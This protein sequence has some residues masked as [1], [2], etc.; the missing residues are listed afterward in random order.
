M[1]D[2]ELLMHLMK[3]PHMFVIDGSFLEFLFS[4]F[5]QFSVERLTKNLP[6]LPLREAPHKNQLFVIRR[7]IPDENGDREAKPQAEAF[8]A[9]NRG[10]PLVPYF[11]SD[12]PLGRVPLVDNMEYKGYKNLEKAA[13]ITLEYRLMLD[14]L[15]KKDPRKEIILTPVPNRARFC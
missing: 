5:S 2:I 4:K 8:A 12:V 15:R 7:Y 3:Y 6:K 11:H 14:K 9:A 13:M 1:N 10:T